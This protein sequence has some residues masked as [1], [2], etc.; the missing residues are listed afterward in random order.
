[1]WA[2][3]TAIDCEAGCAGML[4]ENNYI[5]DIA[6][7]NLSQGRYGHAIFWQPFSTSDDSSSTV[8]NNRIYRVDS[9]F[10]MAVSAGSPGGTI[11]V[12]NNTCVDFRVQG[13]ADMSAGTFTGTLSNANNIF[14]TTAYTP[15]GYLF[16]TRSSIAAPT[17]TVF[18]CTTCGSTIARWN[19][20]NYTAATVLSALGSNNQY[21]DPN[22]DK[23]GGIPPTLKLVAA[24][25]AA[26]S[27]AVV[28]V[29]EATVLPASCV[30]ATAAAAAVVDGGG[31]VVVGAAGIVAGAPA[32]ASSTARTTMRFAAEN[33]G[34]HDV[35]VS[36]ASGVFA[37]T[38]TSVGS[39]TRESTTR[40]T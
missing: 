40:Y 8:R 10:T 37:I 14:S 17:N 9:C 21:G 22:I 1:M 31:S 28:V 39:T 23:S 12:Y 15:R 20:V 25:G 4:L 19:S 35:S 38:L 26:V 24:S 3:S 33:F 27:A 6:T 7:G 11:N 5:H 36:C 30:V 2:Q 34:Q 29:S 16:D 18:Y 13:F 32:D